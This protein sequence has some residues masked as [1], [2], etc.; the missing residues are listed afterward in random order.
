MARNNLT[1]PA[2]YYEVDMGT[3]CVVWSDRLKYRNE[4]YKTTK[5]HVF[6]ASNVTV[7]ND[8]STGTKTYTIKT[9]I[10][11]DDWTML[12]KETLSVY[13]ASPVR[14]RF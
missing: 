14:E 4:N 10:G 12:I 11:E 6:S 1:V 5:N 9:T 7:H 13:N 8:I 2:S 3:P